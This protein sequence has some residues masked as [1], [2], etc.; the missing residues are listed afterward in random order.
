MEMLRGGVGGGGGGLN[1]I[2]CE[3]K[4]SAPRKEPSCFWA[5]DGRRSRSQKKM[6]LGSLVGK[7]PLSRFKAGP[8]R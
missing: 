1:P 8:K 5:R 6:W 7:G 4:E 3:K 2:S